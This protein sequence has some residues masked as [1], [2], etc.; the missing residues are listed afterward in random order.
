VQRAGLL[1]AADAPRLAST[2]LNP[3]ETYDIPHSEHG[4]AMPVTVTWAGRDYRVRFDAGMTTPPAVREHAP[5]RPL[6]I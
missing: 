3:S 1:A 4:F 6:T 2:G 5:P